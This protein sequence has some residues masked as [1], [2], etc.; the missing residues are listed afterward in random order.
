MKIT[1]AILA[2]M[3]ALA[4]AENECRVFDCGTIDQTEGQANICASKK[5]DDA[6]AWE[7][8]TCPDAAPF[9]QTT[10]A[11]WTTPAGIPDTASCALTPTTTFGNK[12]VTADPGIGVDGDF[13]EADAHCFSNGNNAATCIENVCTSPNL[14]DATCA[15]SDDKECPRTLHCSAANTCLAF[16]ATDAVCTRQGQCA[17]GSFCVK[18]EE[19]ATPE[20]KCK[21]DGSIAL[22]AIFSFPEDTQ[23]VENAVKT[24]GGLTV[25]TS[26]FQAACASLSQVTLTGDNAGKRQCRTA[27]KSSNSDF[28]RA[29]TTDSCEIVSFNDDTDFEK[30]NTRTVTPKC[31]FNKSNKAWCPV[32]IGDDKA[33]TYITAGRAAVKDFSCHRESLNSP[34]GGSVCAEFYTEIQK[35][36]HT[37]DAFLN[38]R[39]T[40]VVGDAAHQTWAN[41]ADNAD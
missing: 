19:E 40:T 6:T 20:F 25:T 34:E 11:A 4:A 13:C 29:A 9:C 3:I 23:Q 10:A 21:A 24:E 41:T 7:A 39:L 8:Q 30:E 14:A 2:I 15:N 38:F 32:Q 5:G 18:L 37:S 12:F 17:I 36:E 26:A 31:G 22:G 35:V 27:D 28:S 1:L 33:Q 16:L